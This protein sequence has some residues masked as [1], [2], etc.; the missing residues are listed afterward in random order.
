MHDCTAAESMVM[1]EAS[2]GTTDANA[3]SGTGGCGG[4]AVFELMAKLGVSK[5]GFIVGS[6]TVTHSKGILLATATGLSCL[7]PLYVALQ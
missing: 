1:I 3:V 2:S 6:G 5:T 7:R 4:D